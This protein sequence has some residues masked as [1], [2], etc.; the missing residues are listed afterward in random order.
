MIEINFS[1]LTVGEHILSTVVTDSMG[2]SASEDIFLRINTPP[3]EPILS[4]SP[5]SPLTNQNLIPNI[6]A[7]DQDDD[8]LTFSYQWK[9]NGVN[10]PFL[11]VSVSSVPILSHEVT[12]VGDIWSL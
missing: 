3:D 9:K 8:V 2:L 4:I 5:S 12:M 10:T 6:T 7:I 1:E 11:G